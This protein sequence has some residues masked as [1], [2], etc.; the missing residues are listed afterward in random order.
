MQNILTFLAKYNSLENP[1]VIKNT[2]S[3]FIAEYLSITSTEV[4]VV[5]K[6]ESFS[7]IASP[8]IKQELFLKKEDFTLEFKRRFPKITLGN[9][10]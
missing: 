3:E 4:V 9:L 1:E 6:K 7:I 8:Y 10:L 5:V 2:I